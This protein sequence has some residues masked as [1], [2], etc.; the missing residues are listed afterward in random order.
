[1]A[2]FDD[3]NNLKALTWPPKESVGWHNRNETTT[4]LHQSTIVSSRCRGVDP[5]SSLRSIE[6]A[7]MPSWESRSRSRTGRHTRVTRGHAHHPYS[8]H[9]CSRSPISSTMSTS[10]F[11]RR[12]L[13]PPLCSRLC[14]WGCLCPRP[15]TL[16]PWRAATWLH[17]WTPHLAPSTPR[18]HLTCRD[19]CCFCDIAFPHH[20]TADMRAVG[21]A[22]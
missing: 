18:L 7:R 9:L 6:R 12:P 22:C 13:H 10:S 1:M 19:H 4:H 16:C 15:P 2:C 21:R 11:C 8:P 3:P 14:L 5:F 17:V 20:S